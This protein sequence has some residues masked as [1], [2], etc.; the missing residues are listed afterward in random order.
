MACSGAPQYAQGLDDATTHAHTPEGYQL[1]CE[2]KGG[3]FPQSVLGRMVP[4][5]EPRL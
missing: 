4:E 5:L 1:H 3:T 2:Y